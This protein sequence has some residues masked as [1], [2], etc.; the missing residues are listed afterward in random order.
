MVSTPS[1]D[2][3]SELKGPPEVRSKEKHP[4]ESYVLCRYGGNTTTKKIFKG[5]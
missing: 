1:W 3:Q 5:Q 2:Y 4:I